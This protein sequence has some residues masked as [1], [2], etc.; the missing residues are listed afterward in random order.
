MFFKALKRLISND[1]LAVPVDTAAFGDPLAEQVSWQRILSASANF[2]ANKL[3]D[4][5]PERLHYRT[6]FFPLLIGFI[7][8][9]AG[10]LMV[11]MQLHFRINFWPLLIIG[12][13]FSLS[14][15]TVVIQSALPVVFDRR[16]R[17]FYRGV[18]NRQARL[19]DENR[20]RH[21][22]RFEQIHAIQLIRKL[23]E[24]QSASD[25]PAPSSFMTIY[26]LNLVLHDTRRIHVA[27]YLDSQNIRADAAK[28]GQL[29]QVPVWDGIG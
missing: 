20:A 13:I 18:L 19:A 26:E 4:T 15:L 12:P 8:V 11:A 23:V 9:L 28:I 27:D 6:T 3:M 24:Q 14:G 1:P 21:A 29:V 7:F 16:H 2:Q 22:A 25:V 17:L 10:A 5:D